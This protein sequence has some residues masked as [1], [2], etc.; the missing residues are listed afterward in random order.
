MVYASAFS[1][2]YV[3]MILVLAVLFFGQLGF[4]YRSKLECR[5][6]R[7]MW[8]WCSFVPALVFGVALGNLLQGVPFHIDE[9]TRLFYKGNFFQLLNPFGLL[10][11][12]VSLTMLVTQGATYLQMRNTGEIYLCSIAA[13]QIATL[14]MALCFLLAGI[15]LT[16]GI[17]GYVVTSALDTMAEQWHIRLVPAC[18]TST[19]IRCCGRWLC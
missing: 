2:F 12:I 11:G 6:W 5:R 15:W 17:D 10:A 3:A 13:A 9:Y 8:D 19:R 7:N 1:G 4:D 18:S 16:K 14:M